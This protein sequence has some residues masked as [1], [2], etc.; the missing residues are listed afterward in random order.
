VKKHFV[1]QI[2]I[3]AV[4]VAGCRLAKPTAQT[5]S[6]G[7]DHALYIPISDPANA[8]E[9]TGRLI[10]PNSAQNERK[11]DGG[12]FFEIHNAPRGKELHVGK[13]VWLRFKDTPEIRAWTKAVT[14]DVHFDAITEA[15][16]QSGNKH[17][18]R[19]NGWK[20]VQ[21]LESLAGAH[22]ADDTY[23]LLKN[24]V[25]L[26]SNVMEIET[27]PV[28]I[29]G[30][31]QALVTFVSSSPNGT[32][33]VRHY[34]RD[35]GRF[36]GA[37]EVVRAPVTVPREGFKTP[38]TSLFQIENSDLNAAGWYIFGE[39]KADVFEIGGLE[40]RRLTSLVP[41]SNLSNQQTAL[42]FIRAG[43]FAN[44]RY[45][46]W[47][48]DSLDTNGAAGTS[49]NSAREMLAKPDPAV[50]SLWGGN[51]LSLVVHVFGWR[52]GPNGSP[53][54]PMGVT[55]GHFAFGVAKT[56]RD[57]FTGDPRFLIEYK[58]VYAHNREGIISGS[59][60]YHSYM[61]NTLRGWMYTLPVSDVLV[62]T[63]LL[64]TDYNFGGRRFSPMEGF[65]RE[66]EKMTA[67]YRT[68]PGNGA[69]VVNTATSCVQDSHAALYA[70][71]TKFQRS[72]D[73]DPAVKKWLLENP[74]SVETQFMGR[75]GVQSAYSLP[76]L[77]DS[78]RDNILP[79]FKTP[80]TW[81]EN[82][83]DL[84]LSRKDISGI[85]NVFAFFNHPNTVLP[86]KAHDVMLDLLV[87]NYRA[88]LWVIRTDGI[89]GHL[90]GLEPRPPSTLFR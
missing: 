72:V 49:V 73:A 50:V 34:N 43:I 54:Q 86:R 71:L 37:E 57:R 82:A 88:R 41:T 77:I 63:P 9:W 22:D 61:G 12:V 23:V 16:L 56:V 51:E 59:H 31:M 55:T 53:P 19:V 17:P 40:P 7:A 5:S 65:L 78:V 25:M 89:G 46:S 75:P 87:R 26:G 8:M 39:K 81:K 38:Q 3:V 29:A 80:Q 83:A 10:L 58:Q 44:P 90:P 48:I 68:G 18:T 13:K 30:K 47:H 4:G 11:P 6:R 36:D 62:R 69:S 35:T 64:Y 24:G 45:G 32:H 28:M 85:G 14:T 79:S 52:G 21:P 20:A 60:M 33:K 66:L 15:S 70:A 27:E 76:S 67:R 84:A 1:T 74:T 42:D 2:L